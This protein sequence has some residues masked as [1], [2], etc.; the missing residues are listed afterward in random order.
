[1]KQSLAQFVTPESHTAPVTMP[2]L[3]LVSVLLNEHR[4]HVHCRR[5]KDSYLMIVQTCADNNGGV[6]S[7][8]LIWT[9][10]APD[11]RAVWR[12]QSQGL[13]STFMLVGQSVL[14]KLC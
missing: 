14:G 9:W 7:R 8:S 13:F 3:E 2:L 4:R 12:S 1:M 6:L 11:R 5:Q 10:K